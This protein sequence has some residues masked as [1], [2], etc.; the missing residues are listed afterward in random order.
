MKALVI[1]GIGLLASCRDPLP[2]PAPET[3]LPSRPGP[4][5]PSTRPH[6]AELTTI[7]LSSLFPRQQAGTVLLYDARP[8]FAAGFGKIPGAISWPRR[9]FDAGL[10]RHEPE[11]RAAAKAGHPVVLYCTDAACPDARAMAEQLVARGHPVS[12]LDGGIAAWK[13]AGLPTE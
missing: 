10:S 9:Q 13:E 8:A 2:L 12:I 7:D 5:Q 6:S 3:P 1:A 11:I 4:P